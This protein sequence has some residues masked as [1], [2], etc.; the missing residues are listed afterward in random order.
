M[1]GAA[2]M[3]RSAA[4]RSRRGRI[5]AARK[6]SGRRRLFAAAAEREPRG[7]ISRRSTRGG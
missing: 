1:I 3:A 6:D 7:P 2:D 5:R 4:R